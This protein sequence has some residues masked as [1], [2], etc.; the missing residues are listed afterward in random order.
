MKARVPI[1][2]IL[3]LLA[4]LPFALASCG[5]SVGPDDE[6]PPVEFDPDAYGL[7][8]AFP[9]LSFVQPLYITDAGDGSGR[10]FV[11]EKRGVIRVFP[12]DPSASSSE[13]F[14][15]IRGQVDD[16]GSEEG[17][18]GLA[19]H[20]DFES[21]GHFFV[22]YTA[23]GPPRTIVSRFT[24]PGP[25][26][27]NPGGETEILSFGQ[28]FDNH[29][30][31]HMAFGPGGLL[32]IAAG[33]GGS[34]GDPFGNAQDRTTLLGN[35]LRIDIDGSE[36][37]RNYAIAPRNPY[38]DNDRGYR[39]E[40]Y[41]WGLRNPWRF[42]FDSS[43]GQM[44]AGDVGQG[45]YEEIDIIRNGENYGWNIMEGAHCYN[46]SSCDTTG[47][48]LPVWEY[49][50]GD[51]NRSVTGGYVYRGSELPGL[52]GKYIYA[53]FVSGRVWALDLSDP[54]AP[55]NYELLGPGPNISSFGTDS[56]NELYLTAFDGNIYRLSRE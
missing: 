13:I 55:R 5:D 45:R 10:L 6:P 19:F 52:E 16:S 20:P 15:D 36:G 24:V 51:N 1:A 25:G 14:L 46:A 43:T 12:N 35:I 30:G 33:D 40:I 4:A 26:E 29:N 17:L 9:Q 31:G 8:E 48:T 53:D 54:E 32:Y 37:G 34:G 27:G 49:P 22:N 47:L 7:E 38:A 2:P 44:I 3:L 21:N 42:S 56:G 50:H 41:A 23:S 18:L 39:E 28:P 11:V